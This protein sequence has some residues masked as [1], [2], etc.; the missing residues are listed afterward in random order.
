MNFLHDLSEQTKGFFDRAA[1][2][3]AVASIS[4]SQVALYVSIAAGLL[5]AAW[6]VQRFYDRHF[7][8]RSSDD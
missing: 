7:L 4:L 8:D 5:S 6:V 3:G 2:L 1:I